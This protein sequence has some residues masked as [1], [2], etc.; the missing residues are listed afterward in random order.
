MTIIILLVLIGS[1]QLRQNAETE[2]ASE[3]LEAPSQVFLKPDSLIYEEDSLK[4]IAQWEGHTYRF[5]YKMTEGED[6]R[7]LRRRKHLPCLMLEGEL[8][9]AREQENFGG[10]DYRAYLVNQGIY[11]TLKI[12]KIKR[13]IWQESWN[14]VD[15]LSVWRAG[16]IDWIES[17]YPPDLASYMTGLLL[18]YL[19]AS[20][21]ERGHVYRQLGIF[22]LFALSGMQVAFFTKLY[23]RILA[24]FG[25]TKESL[26][27]LQWFFS[28]IYAG[29]TG[30]TPSVLRALV[31]Q[32][33]GL[34]G[35]RGMQQFW[36]LL[37]LLAALT[38]QYFRDMGAILSLAFAFILQVLAQDRK[39]LESWKQALVVALASLPILCLFF[40]EYQPLGI[41]FTVLLSFLFDRILLPLFLALLL[42]A[43]WTKG[44]VVNN[45]LQGLDWCLQKA[46][47][48]LPGPLILGQPS[49]LIFLGLLV[50]LAFMWDSR[51]SKR[52]TRLWFSIFLIGLV[53][54]K[55][56]FVN[57]ITLV[58][59]G[60]GDSIFL[61]D[62]QGRH[63]LIDV[64]G[65]VSFGPKPKHAIKANAEYS[66][67]PYLKSRGIDHLEHVFLTH[68]DADHV[69]DLLVV[70]QEIP[71][72]NLY[73]SPGSLHKAGFLDKLQATQA[74][75]HLVEPGQTWPIFDSQLQALYPL[76]EGQGDNNDSLVLYG[77]FYQVR[78]LF[79]GDLEQE[80]E[81]ILMKNYPDLSVDVL[82]LGHHG[83]K[84]SSTPAFLDYLHPSLA[85]ISAGKDNRYHHPHEETLERLGE[86]GISW[87]RTDQEGAIRL[88]GWWDWKL[89]TVRKLEE[90]R[91]LV[92]FNRW[93]KS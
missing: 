50:C 68:P 15:K 5:S 30:W 70:D 73:I 36:V 66:L 24:G 32:Q 80:G 71:I 43:P 22:H 35:L 40:S 2:K 9:E 18:G 62:W 84:G 20:F 78:F 47:S 3:E 21:A 13:I 25:L 67:I 91:R 37:L 77:Q 87:H 56:P 31:Q 59:I 93:R 64:G 69:G 88:Y 65:K 54:T 55:F 89:E 26:N 8:G 44:E 90:E 23:R 6:L 48:Y 42:L 29:L 7:Y 61:R 52:R 92:A 72:S 74:Q 14:L 12:Q 17:T 53:L 4:G 41:F 1:W 19:P 79:T 86:R 58:N 82:K 27:Q 11:H 46:Q 75:I 81:E 33:L 57:E 51:S 38:P 60:Q 49:F 16:C 76:E 10:F 63:A 39:R 85:L 45:L 34:L 28:I 83:S